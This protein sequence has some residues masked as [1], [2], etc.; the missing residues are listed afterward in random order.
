M[1]RSGA[2]GGGVIPGRAEG[3]PP[4]LQVPRKCLPAARRSRPAPSPAQAPLQAARPGV[5]AGD[6]HA[7]STSGFP[8]FREGGPVGW[9]ASCEPAICPESV[10]SEL[11]IWSPECA[12]KGSG[13]GPG[14]EKEDTQEEA[15]TVLAKGCKG[16]P[17]P[18]SDILGPWD[19]FFVFLNS[20]LWI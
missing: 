18:A 15:R 14:L 6:R 5:P 10:T 16:S 20:F 9:S 2:P 7:E 13:V 3:G 17:A 4:P 12:G 1:G 8:G 19:I 11:L